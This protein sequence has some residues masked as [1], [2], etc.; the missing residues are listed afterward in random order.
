MAGE[1]KSKTLEDLK[2][3]FVKEPTKKKK[4]GSERKEVVNWNLDSRNLMINLFFN[5]LG[6]KGKRTAKGKLPSIKAEVLENMKHPI[7]MEIVKF[8][9]DTKTLQS[10]LNVSSYLTSSKF[11]LE[12]GEKSSC[13][14]GVIKF[15]VLGFDNIERIYPVAAESVPISVK[16]EVRKAFIVPK[17]NFIDEMDLNEEVKSILSQVEE[18]KQNE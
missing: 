15:N 6:E 12:K 14:K 7:A 8:R 5:V 4:V 3:M 11:F 18:D 1:R 10:F 2:E 9:S 13:E 17:D 16:K